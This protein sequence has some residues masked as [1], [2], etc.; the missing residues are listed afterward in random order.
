MRLL[1]REEKFFVDFQNQARTICQ[2]AQELSD[3]V[4][5]GNTHMMEAARHIRTLE[6]KGDELIHDIVRRLNQ[7]FLTPLDPEDIHSLASHMDDLLDGIE[8]VAHCLVA[9]KVEP[10]PEPVVELADII[11]TAAES[12]SRA[13]DALAHH[14]PMMEHCIEINRLEDVA[15]EAYRRAV[16]DLFSGAHDALSVIK[17]KE[18]Y[19]ALEMTTDRCEDVADVLQAVLV[20]NG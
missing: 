17:L 5:G 18:I 16:A 13:I 15:D 2:A 19:D 11:R 3:A 10:I 6:Q 20:K 9:Y 7:T 8:E 12:V 14:T 4:K 1:P